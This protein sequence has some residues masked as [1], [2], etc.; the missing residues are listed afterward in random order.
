[1]SGKHSMDR[2]KL[3]S[4]DENGNDR[5]PKA[6]KSPRFQNHDSHNVI[7]LKKN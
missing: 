5:M 6:K 1:M 7:T 3:L 4:G 2:I